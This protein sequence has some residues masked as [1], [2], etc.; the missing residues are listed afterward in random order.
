MP[1]NTSADTRSTVEGP[2]CE[3]LIIETY[4]TARPQSAN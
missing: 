2:T 4:V 1:E 3:Q